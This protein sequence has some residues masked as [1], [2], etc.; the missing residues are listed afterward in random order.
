MCGMILG[1]VGVMTQSGCYYDKE[2]KLYPVNLSS[3]DTTHISYVA[4]VKPIFVAN[5]NS[6]HST[7]NASSLGGGYDLETFSSLTN[8]VNNGRLICDVEQTGC[9]NMPKGAPK[10]SACDLLKI[11]AWKN[12]GTP[13]N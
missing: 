11:T 3:C 4:S 7:V 12:A 9:D 2:D 8:Q 6:C 10:L 1:L 13:N 5:C